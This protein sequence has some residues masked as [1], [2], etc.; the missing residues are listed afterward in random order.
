MS[1]VIQGKIGKQ[2][3]RERASGRRPATVRIGYVPLMDAAPLIAADALGYFERAGL[4]VNLEEELG[5]GSIRDKIVY[6][7]LDAAHAPGGLLFSILLG[8]H[9]PARSVETDLVISLQGNAITLSRRLWH[10]G[11]TDGDSFRMMIRSESPRKPRFAVVSQYSSHLFLLHQ[12]LRKIGVNPETEV[13]IAILPPPLVVEHM[14]QGHIDGFCAGE[15]W[16]SVA[17]LSRDGWIVATSSS[18]A[19]NH[20]EKILICTQEM[21]GNFPEE[22]AALRKAI[23]AGCQ[24]CESAANRSQLIDLLHERLFVSVSKETL[25]NC[26]SNPAQTGVL[27]DLAQGPLIRFHVADGNRA[28]RERAVWVLNSLTQTKALPLD[29]SQ[30]RH[31]L[32][33]FKD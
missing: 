23:L 5:W 30:R 31:C 29:P 18:L 4:R 32:E 14:R 24:Y 19:P 15:P 25:G 10:K 28:S 26:L 22:Y 1:V 20:P 9:A 2:P 13:S 27:P 16:N 33:A 3:G 7:E 21:A 6:G 8:I 11:V 17:A 12:W